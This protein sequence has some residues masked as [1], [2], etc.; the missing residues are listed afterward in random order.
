LPGAV[1][2]GGVLSRKETSM[3]AVLTRCRLWWLG[4]VT[5]GGA[6]VLA[7]CDPNVREGVLSGVGSAAT[8]LATTFIDAFF[9]GLLNDAA[10][11]DA[12]VVQA[13]QDFQPQIFT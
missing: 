5:A 2:P 4:V 8:G 10:E 3:R 9:Q 13:V 7:G 1:A 11:E 12:T 6:F